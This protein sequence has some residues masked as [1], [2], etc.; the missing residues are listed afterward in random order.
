MSIE[1]P[2]FRIGLAGFTVKQQEDLGRALACLAPASTFWE[3]G[4]FGV[5]DAWWVNGARTQLLADGTLRIASGTPTGRNTH[6]NLDEVDRPIAFAQPI[7]P[8]DF[9]PTLKFDPQSDQAMVAVLEQFEQALRPQAAQFGLAS[10]VIAQESVLGT[11]TYHVAGNGRLLAVVNFQGDAAVRPSL[12][13]VDFEGSVWTPV[14][15]DQSHMPAAFIRTSFAQLMW[16]Y[17]LRTTRDVLP[18]RYRRGKIYFRRLP[19]VPQRLMRDAH[20]LLLRELTLAPGSF[21]ELGRRTSLSPEQLGRDLAALYLVGAITSNAKRAAGVVPRNG[22]HAHSQPL[23]GH[24]VAPSSLELGAFSRPRPAHG[25]DLTAP[26]PMTL[27]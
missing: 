25:G 8:R 3:I 27:E 14:T 5:A 1:L 17:A 9:E 18:E 16:Q 24:S 19:R 4:P 22:D 2:V 10:E 6:L 7:A 12:T 20:L 21:D 23:S 15:A 26:A 11:G 13:A